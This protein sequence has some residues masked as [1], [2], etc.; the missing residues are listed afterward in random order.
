[1]QIV[2]IVASFLAVVAR[3]RRRILSTRHSSTCDLDN[4]EVLPLQ[5][6]RL[7]AADVSPF[8]VGPEDC[9]VFE[10]RNVSLHHRCAEAC[11]ELPSLSSPEVILNH[12]Y[13]FLC[14]TC[15][16]KNSDGLCTRPRMLECYPSQWDCCRAFYWPEA[17]LDAHYSLAS[18][19]AYQL[20]IEACRFYL[21]SSAAPWC[22]MAAVFPSFHCGRQNL[23]VENDLIV[24]VE[25]ILAGTTE[26]AQ[27]AVD[28]IYSDLSASMLGPM[29]YKQPIRSANEDVS[30]MHRKHL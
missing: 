4:R 27:G 14:R 1:M 12:P 25:S 19:S 18:L 21:G 3:R 28:A 26:S 29:I 11:G 16:Y 7:S 9:W 6:R 8:I 5:H 24:C 20:M 15:Q 13:Q 23:T 30:H 22:Y 17:C 2:S 10:S